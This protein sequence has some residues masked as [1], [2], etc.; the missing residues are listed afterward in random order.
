MDTSLPFTTRVLK[1]R[2]EPTAGGHA[3]DFA[4][5]LPAS[6]RTKRDHIV[7][8][9]LEPE[10]LAGELLVDRLNDVQDSL[11]IC[12]RPMPPR[13]LREFP[14]FSIPASSVLR[15]SVHDRKRI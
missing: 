2:A 1:P 14:A 11:W 15:N 3:P 10:F 12:G 8:P 13:A 5:L 9:Q 6:H 7:I 4:P